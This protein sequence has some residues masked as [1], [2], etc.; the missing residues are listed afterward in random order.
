LL[1]IKIKK[2]VNA[3]RQNIVQKSNKR[4]DE[5]KTVKR[6]NFSEENLIKIDFCVICQML[7]AKAPTTFLISFVVESIQHPKQQQQ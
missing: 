4:S 2:I 6:T 3:K 1:A 7:L 5:R